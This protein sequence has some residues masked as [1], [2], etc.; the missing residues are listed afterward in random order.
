MK[1]ICTL[2]KK[3]LNSQK[4]YTII[5]H[6]K[7][8]VKKKAAESSLPLYRKRKVLLLAERHAVGALVL[9]GVAFVGTDHDAVQGAV[10]FLLTVMGTLVHGAFDGLV[11]VTVHNAFLLLLNSGIVCFSG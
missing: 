1:E 2:D 5:R 4:S 11:C 6:P 7:R 3:Y 8:F 9:G 10:V